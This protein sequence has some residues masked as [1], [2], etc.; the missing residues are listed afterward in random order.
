MCITLYFQN[1]TQERECRINKEIES[2]ESLSERVDDERDKI[3]AE[4]VPV[5]QT[6]VERN[7]AMYSKNESE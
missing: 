4:I 1:S 6:R 5:L 3:Q 2:T 7:T